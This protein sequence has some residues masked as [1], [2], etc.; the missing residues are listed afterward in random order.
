MTTFYQTEHCDN[1]PICEKRPLLE[2]EQ[3]TALS[4]LQSILQSYIFFHLSFIAL[5][6]FE[7]TISTYFAWKTAPSFLLASLLATLFLTFFSYLILSYYFQGK[8]REQMQEL[9]N[10]FI[11]NCTRTLS[12][13]W[14]KTDTKLSLAQALFLLIQNIYSPQITIC[15]V[16][17]FYFAG[18]IYQQCSFWFHVRDLFWLSERLHKEIINI[19]LEAIAE[20]PLDVSVHTSFAK[21]YLA[22]SDIYQIPQQSALSEFYPLQR[23]YQTENIQKKRQK[24]LL[25]AVQEL[26]I[27][28]DL[29]PNDPWVYTTFA[30][31]YQKLGEFSN[32]LLMYE[33]LSEMQPYEP[34][35]LF[36][37]GRLYFKLDQHAKGLEIFK[38]LKKEDPVRASR[39]MQLHKSVNFAEFS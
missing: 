34:Q 10:A 17:P 7:L 25:Y 31:A 27:L 20:D 39:L 33:K 28:N 18:K 15:K 37:L 16:P 38:R 9:S 8:K 24:T 30:K 32:E 35:V 14:E 19:H 3:K 26:K 21:M 2:S 22:F 12:T 5:L 23:I 29:S 13:T 4:S 6:G 11:Q 1:D 36:Q